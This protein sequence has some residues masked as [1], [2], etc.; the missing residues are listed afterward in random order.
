MSDDWKS[1]TLQRREIL[2]NSVITC[3]LF[4]ALSDLMLL[5]SKENV[6][7]I[8]FTHRCNFRKINVVPKLLY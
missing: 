7:R 3:K 6:P 4:L 5:R 2:S 8:N 1:G